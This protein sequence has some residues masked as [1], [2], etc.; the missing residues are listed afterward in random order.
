MINQAMWESNRLSSPLNWNPPGG[1]TTKSFPKVHVITA[2]LDMLHEDGRAYVN[3]LK[4]HEVTV[5]HEHYDSVH[6][7]FGISLF[8]YGRKALYDVCKLLKENLL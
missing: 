3:Y 7:F 8:P 4:K 6:G 1:L 2:E 5:T